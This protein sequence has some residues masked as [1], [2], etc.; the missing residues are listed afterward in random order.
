MAVGKN[1]A[2][3]ER[4]KNKKKNKNQNPLKT[5]PKDS[6]DPGDTKRDCIASRKVREE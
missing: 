5:N 1:T 3:G 2:G 4:K 6:L